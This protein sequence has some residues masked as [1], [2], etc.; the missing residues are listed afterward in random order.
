MVTSRCIYVTTS[1][2]SSCVDPGVEEGTQFCTISIRLR[3]ASNDTSINFSIKETSWFTLLYR[4]Y[5]HDHCQ[6][7]NTIQ[8]YRHRADSMFAPSQWQTPLLCNGVSHWLGVSIE[9]ASR[10]HQMEKFSALLSLCAGNSPATGEFPS[11]RPVTRSF[12]IFFGLRLNKRLSKKS[13]GWWSQTPSRHLWHHCNEP[14]DICFQLNSSRRWAWRW[15]WVCL[16]LRPVCWWWS[17]LGLVTIGWRPAGHDLT[18][19][20]CSMCCAGSRPRVVTATSRTARSSVMRHNR[21][22]Q[23]SPLSCKTSYPKISWSL[24]TTRLCLKILQSRWNL[25]SS[26]AI[27]LLSR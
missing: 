9:S 25:T 1:R 21:R 27:L 22:R 2:V 16:S 19:R 17:V 6:D 24:E 3:Q 13:W 11:Q 26:L 15:P 14:C 20:R 12:D 5:Q 7:D 8:Y 23:V 10:R 18:D 4:H